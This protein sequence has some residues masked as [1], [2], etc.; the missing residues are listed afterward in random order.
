MHP[1]PALI[2]GTR[3]LAVSDSVIRWRGWPLVAARTLCLAVMT[4]ALAIAFAGVWSDFEQ[5]RSLAPGAIS[6][7]WTPDETRAALDQA[8]LSASTYAAAFL[9][10]HLIY[11]PAFF[12]IA[13]FLVWRKSDEPMALFVAL[14]LSLFAANWMPNKEL[15]PG[16]LLV[17]LEVVDFLAWACFLAFFCLFPDGRFVPGWTRWLVLAWIVT[18]PPIKYLVRP[19]QGFVVVVWLSLLACAAGTQVYR[20]RRMAGPLQRQQIKWVVFGFAPSILIVFALLLLGLLFPTLLEPG[21]SGL[22][23][24]ALFHALSDILF[25]LIPLSISLAILRYRL[26]GIDVIITRALAYG[27]LTVGV[28]GIYVAV[29]GTLGVIF[30]AG[31]SLS[32]SLVATGLVAVLFQPLRARLQ[33]GANHLVYGERDEPYAVLARLGQRLEATLAPDAILP[34]LVE[35]VA[36]A[37]KLPYVALALQQDEA[38]TIVAVAG[39]PDARASDADLL[40]LPLVYQQEPVGELLLKPRAPG[41]E[42]TPGDRRL[43][44]DLARQAGLAA[45]SVQLT[46]ELEHARARLVLA[47][48]EE[49]RRLRRD[50]HDGLGPLLGGLTLKLGAVRQMLRRDLP[51]ADALLTDLTAQ[52]QVAVEDIRRLVSALRPP[53]LDE[54]GLVGALQ[55]AAT[56]Y[57]L[58]HL[59]EAG[60]R[61]TVE[62]LAPLP[63]L[64]AALEVAAYHIAR[65]ALTNVVRHA[66]ARR[67]QVNLAFDPTTETLSLDIH[68]DGRG[69]PGRYRAGVGLQSMRERAVELGGTCEVGP[70]SRGGTR[71]HALLP[72]P[73]PA[74]VR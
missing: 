70:A 62:A 14:F 25:L 36:E 67:C 58:S 41:E 38:L 45:H 26:W 15:L 52:T 48:E 7:S 34:V 30:Q 35:T 43:L 21:R 9:T 31:D 53:A 3:P 33:R 8:D 39:T 42:F 11:V 13:A 22:L 19:P 72:C 46:A 17:L 59:D 64:P 69:L 32:I 71:V 49:R 16:N 23:L 24:Q 54:L 40:R 12:A 56:R 6:A 20:Y 50:L 44:A 60:L 51:A 68:D 28:I 73:P 29:V 10:L 61:V 1:T 74:S 4:F 63:L 2:E 18:E 66:H 37:L 27:L 47:R 5:T 65:E 55:Q 57:D